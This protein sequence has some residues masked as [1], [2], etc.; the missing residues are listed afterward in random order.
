[1]PANDGT[2]RV[3]Y[4]MLTPQRGWLLVEH[5]ALEYDHATAAAKMR[6]VGLPEGYA[7]ALASGLWPSCDVLPPAERAAR[8]KRLVPSRLFWPSL[9]VAA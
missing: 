9:A 7:E 5:H 4:A 3:W 6:A 2:P 1:M 8:G